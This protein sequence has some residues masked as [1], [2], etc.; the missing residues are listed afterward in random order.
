[1]PLQAEGH[2]VRGRPEREEGDTVEEVPSPPGVQKEDAKEVKGKGWLEEQMDM[3]LT[4]RTAAPEGIGLQMMANIRLRR[5]TS[6]WIW[7]R[8]LGG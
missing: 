4:E 1:M 2:V 8:R 3:E 6:L 7:S 5:V